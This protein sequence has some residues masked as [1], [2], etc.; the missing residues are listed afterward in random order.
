[1]SEAVDSLGEFVKAGYLVKSP[2]ISRACV[3][4]WHRRWFLLMDSRLVFPLAERYVRLVYYQSETDVRRLADPKG[5]IDLN[6]CLSVISSSVPVKNFKFVFDVSTTE[7]VYHLAADSEEERAEWVATLKELLF[8]AQKNGVISRPA[9]PSPSPS[10]HMPPAPEVSRRSRESRLQRPGSFAASSSKENTGR[11]SPG[12]QRRPLPPVPGGGS[13]SVPSSPLERKKRPLPAPPGEVQASPVGV[14]ASPLTQR[15]GAPPKIPSPYMKKKSVPSPPT[16]SAPRFCR[17]ASLSPPPN[18]QDY[19]EFVSQSQPLDG[20]DCTLEDNYSLAT[21]V[22]RQ[23]NL[24]I[25]FPQTSSPSGRVSSQSNEDYSVLEPIVV[26]GYNPTD[27]DYSHLETVMNDSPPPPVRFAS[28]G[29]RRNHRQK[30]DRPHSAIPDYV[31][32]PNLSNDDY[33]SLHH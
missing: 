21:S 8:S 31:N 10:P 23:K 28:L 13:S 7:R 14:L 30:P 29:T 25:K 4:Q 6:C 11:G 3:S 24:D 12:V 9:P 33:S 16:A 26:H 32:C 27:Q 19:Q 18:A 5:T 20:H 15:K 17:S 1:M 2:P 22:P